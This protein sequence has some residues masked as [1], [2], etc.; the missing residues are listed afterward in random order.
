MVVA[1]VVDTNVVVAALRSEGGAS[2]QVVRGCLQGTYEPLFGA[3]LLAEYEHTLLGRALVG[4][5]VTRE[6]RYEVMAALAAAGRWVSVYFLWRP[7][8]SD[9]TDNHL[10]ELAVAGGAEAIVAHNT[11]DLRSGELLFPSV[12]VLTPAA[13]LKEYPCPP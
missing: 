2:R 7:N 13:F 1:I 10:V 11:R 4:T 6:E 8:L 3:A 5:A 12:R 9:E